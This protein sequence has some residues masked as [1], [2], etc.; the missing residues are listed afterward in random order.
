M[1]RPVLTRLEK[2]EASLLGA[3]CRQN[4]R[5]AAH[6]RLIDQE[7]VSQ[8]SDDELRLMLDFCE[9]KKQGHELTSRQSAA[10]EAYV[11]ALERECQKLG[12]KS[13]AAL[14]KHCVA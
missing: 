13:L 4:N 11:A 3:G 7:V 9:A 8:M 6:R 5:Y 14:D 1:R 12:Y 2:L 10:A